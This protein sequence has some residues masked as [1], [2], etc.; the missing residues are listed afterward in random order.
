MKSNEFGKGL[1]CGVVAIGI[2]ATGFVH[3]LAFGYKMGATKCIKE[4]KFYKE[5]YEAY[6][7][8]ETDSKKR[9]VE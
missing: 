4:L 1:V 5:A 6:M 7:E 8:N 9:D 3:T 2:L